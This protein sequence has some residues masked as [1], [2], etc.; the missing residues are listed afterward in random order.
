MCTHKTSSVYIFYTVASLIIIF[1]FAYVEYTFDLKKLKE[2]IPSGFKIKTTVTVDYNIG[3]VS[4]CGLGVFELSESVGISNSREPLIFLDKNII[5]RAQDSRKKKKYEKWQ[6]IPVN[7]NGGSLEH[8]LFPAWCHSRFASDRYLQKLK[9][10]I[11]K[12]NGFYTTSV[13]NDYALY[14][15]PSL[16]VLVIT[17]STGY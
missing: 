1:S 17:A 11:Q 10:E 16:N 5:S 7:Y 8:G 14:I 6:K 3:I 4:D 13:S 15:I 2:N 12:G 9:V